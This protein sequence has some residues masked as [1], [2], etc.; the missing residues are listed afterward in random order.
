MTRTDHKVK[1]LLMPV[2]LNVFVKY[3][4]FPSNRILFTVNEDAEQSVYLVLNF[5]TLEKMVRNLFVVWIFIHIFLL[6][7]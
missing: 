1:R 4:L 6:F 3:D 5:I 7:L 2:M